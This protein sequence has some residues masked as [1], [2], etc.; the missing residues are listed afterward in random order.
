M[1]V[2]TCKNF[3]SHGCMA[4][5]TKRFE[6]GNQEI[7]RS[8]GLSFRPLGIRLRQQCGAWRKTGDRKILGSRCAVP[9]SRTIP[10]ACTISGRYVI[11]CTVKLATGPAPH[12]RER[13]GGRVRRPAQTPYRTGRSFR[14]LQR[15]QPQPGS[16]ALAGGT[17]PRSGKAEANCGISSARRRFA[18]GKSG[19]NG[20][21][22]RRKPLPVAQGLPGSLPR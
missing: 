1:S 19:S 21:R 13:H 3:P 15:R 18:G 12:P 9:G 16:F 20:P 11:R 7:R 4:A 6:P 10:R 2:D 8:E 5:A 14:I 17:P 22:S